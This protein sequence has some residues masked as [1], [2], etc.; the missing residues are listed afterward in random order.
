MIPAVEVMKILCMG[1]LIPRLISIFSGSHGPSRLQKLAFRTI[2]LQTGE[3]SVLLSL[4]PHLVELDIDVP[5]ADDLLRLIYG[6][7]E[8]MLVP[9]LQ[10]LN[11]HTPVLTAGTQTELF[12]T[13][14]QVRCELGSRKDSDSEDA[15][16]PSLGPG[17]WTTLD[18]LRF[19]FN[20]AKRRDK[21]QKILNN[22]SSSFTPKEAKAINVINS[23][24][25]YIHGNS[26]SFRLENDAV[27]LMQDN[28]LACIEHYR[29]KVTTKVLHV[30]IF[31]WML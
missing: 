26:K 10:A 27:L 14:A 18:T 12:D 15:T 7:G 5:P 24:G 4:T 23:C 8:V 2:P 31:F 17:T 20:K 1:P 28:L 19:V 30:G 16:M 3:L 11:I 6:E 22:R 9:M 25:N 29:D 13:L 21:S